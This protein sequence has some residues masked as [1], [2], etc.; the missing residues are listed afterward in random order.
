MANPAPFCLPLKGTTACPDFEGYSAYIPVTVS[1][2]VTDVASFDALLRE[3][4]ET[5]AKAGFGSAMRGPDQY[6][7][8]GWQGDQLRYFHSALCGYFV[9]LGQW[10]ATFINGNPCNPEL[11]KLPLCSSTVDM[12]ARTW[13][14]VQNN[15]TICPKGPS[16]GAE[17]Y[18]QAILESMKGLTSTDTNCLVG[19]SP[20]VENCGFSTVSEKTAFC[21][22]TVTDNCCGNGNTTGLLGSSGLPVL[23][24][25]AS[26]STTSAIS[27]A[28]GA[29]TV[30]MTSLATTT[31]LVASTFSIT[32]TTAITP[33]KT[34]SENTSS[35]STF[36]AKLGKL[37]VWIYVAA[38]A[39]L[40]LIILTTV[41]CCC[42]RK[43]RKQQA[44]IISLDSEER[45]LSITKLDAEKDGE[46]FKNDIA[47]T[48]NIQRAAYAYIPQNNDELETEEGDEIIVLAEFDDGW[49]RGICLRTNI[50]G[51]FPLALLEMYADEKQNQS[52]V[53][54][55]RVSSMYGQPKQQMSHNS[56]YST[57]TENQRTSVMIS[58]TGK[59]YTVVEHFLPE[60][61]DELE[62]YVGERV[63]LVQPYDDGWG[64]GININTNREGVFPLYCLDEFSPKSGPSKKGNRVSSLYAKKV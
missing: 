57:F 23:A 54:S 64:F 22:G 8:S 47:A 52:Q 29:T 55:N 10:N 14:A 30:M 53:Y 56:V 39:G 16:A 20:D 31:A 37:P 1:N 32:T 50:E 40:F 6:A 3:S 7:C 24:T 18:K 42:I 60:R 27:T 25:N 38:G 2:R 43:A 61:D 45:N 51:F 12:F 35:S 62:L 63:T 36:I 11:S 15:A 49:G 5:D 4:V 17:T 13:D 44:A 46:I 26:N 58:S 33:T 41:L 59:P 19:E 34:A 9:G 21:G 48:S 28:Q